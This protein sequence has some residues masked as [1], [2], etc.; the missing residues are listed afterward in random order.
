MYNYISVVLIMSL[1]L[2]LL[3]FEI[4]ASKRLKDRERKRE[5]IF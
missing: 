5:H 2:L 3:L 1:L 4:L